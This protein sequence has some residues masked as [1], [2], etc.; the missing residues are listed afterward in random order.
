MARGSSH[1]EGGDSDLAGAGDSPVATFSSRSRSSSPTLA[2]RWSDGEE[3]NDS[4]AF[5]DAAATASDDGS[6]ARPPRPASRETADTEGSWRLGQGG[7]ASG[8]KALPEGSAPRR[9]YRAVAGEEHRASAEPEVAPKASKKQ[10]DPV[11]AAL[12]RVRL[13][14]SRE[15]K[16]ARK[17]RKRERALARQRRGA[18]EDKE[19]FLERTMQRLRVRAAEAMAEA[20]RAAVASSMAEHPPRGAVTDVQAFLKRTRGRLADR[21]SM[22]DAADAAAQL[23]QAAEAAAAAAGAKLEEFRRQTEARLQHSALAAFPQVHLGDRRRIAIVGGGPVGL[24]AAVLIAQKYRCMEVCHS[25]ARRPDAPEVIVYEGRP[26]ERHQAR[27]D[28]RIALSPATINLLNSRT[29]GKSKRFYTGMPVA[30]IEGA[31]LHRLEKIAPKGGPFFEHPIEDP[32]GFAATEGFD[33]V[34]WAGGRRSLSDDLRCALGCELQQS[35][36]ERVLVFQFSDLE[37]GGDV[38][39]D[40][41]TAAQQAARWPSFRV[42]LRPG[43]EGV[44]AGWLWLFGLPGD[45]LRKPPP[46]DAGPGSSFR[47]ALVQ[48]LDTSSPGASAVLAAADT[49]QQRIR[50]RG[51]TARW[52]DAAFWSSSR[53]VCDLGDL[54]SRAEGCPIVVLGDAACGKPFYTGTT[55]NGHLRDVAAMVDEIDWTHDGGPFGCSRFWGHEKRYQAEIARC[56]QY[57][58]RSAMAPSLQVQMPKKPALEPL[59]PRQSP[60]PLSP[61]LRVPSLSKTLSLPRLTGGSRLASLSV[62]AVVSELE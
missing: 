53:T 37:V 41:A 51:C 61:A 16:A 32:A 30:D 59:P 18:G 52:V 26:E 50:P 12:R 25:L 22:A 49:F 8:S 58:R 6:P 33:C 14:K 60:R 20:A 9:Q 4:E 28:I 21:G 57:E 10:R 43:V 38:N 55:L 24:W 40:L 2:Q 36:V 62:T 46:Q 34:L 19:A 13:R 31:L 44:C 17:A 29:R 48:V 23:A 11:A 47:E 42:L 1:S 15:A 39:S 54:D 3:S 35:D 45:A 56:A 7:G 27:K 5:E